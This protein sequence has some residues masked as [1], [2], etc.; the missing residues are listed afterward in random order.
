MHKLE[1]VNLR[2]ITGMAEVKSNGV[3]SIDLEALH[4][5]VT[6]SSTSLR[7]AELH[8][9]EDKLR[10]IGKRPPRRRVRYRFEQAA[11]NAP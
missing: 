1:V 7:K 9:L 5:S 10:Y 8:A 11:D 6:S 4:V 3:K 2:E